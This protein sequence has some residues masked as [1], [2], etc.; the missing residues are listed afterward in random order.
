MR[1]PDRPSPDKGFLQKSNNEDRRRI[2]AS[3]SHYGVLGKGKATRQRV[4]GPEVR[5]ATTGLSSA[6]A[7]LDTWHALCLSG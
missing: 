6:S 5:R 4:S 7:R 1:G 3:Y 2:I